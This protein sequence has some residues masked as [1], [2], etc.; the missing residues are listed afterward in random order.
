MLLTV[1]GLMIVNVQYNVI[2]Y[3]CVVSLSK[4]YLKTFGFK[5]KTR[6]YTPGF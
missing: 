4:E 2:F 1:Y 6:T 5:I 3:T